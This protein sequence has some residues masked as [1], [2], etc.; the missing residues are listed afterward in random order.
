MDQQ[1]LGIDVPD[2]AST[3]PTKHPWLPTTTSRRRLHNQPPR[4]I[5][6]TEEPLPGLPP[7]STD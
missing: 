5:T 1:T 6:W 7:A 4:N 2:T 3:P